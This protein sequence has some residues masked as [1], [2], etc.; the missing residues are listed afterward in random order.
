MA[1]PSI[2][3]VK[4]NGWNSDLIKKYDVAGPR[5]TSYPTVPNF[6]SAFRQAEYLQQIETSLKHSLAPLSL[7]VHVPFC[8]NICF[9][10]GCNK[11]VTRDTSVA[12]KYLNYLEKEIRLQSAAIGNRR[13]VMQ[14]HFGGGTPT[15][16]DNAELTE[17]MHALASH[18]KL[19]D[20]QQREY[21]I[22]LDPRTVTSDSLALLRGLGFNRVSF[23]IQDF[24][25]R[26]QKAINR[27]QSY[28]SV[29]ELVSAARLYRF[30]S[31]SFD[32]I[33][34]L[35]FQTP[36]SLSATIDQVTKLSP[37]RIA[38]Y[39]YAHLPERFSSQR[40]IDRLAL[41]SA[42]QKLSMWVQ[43]AERLMAAGYQFIGMDHFVKVDDDLAKA[44]K[45]GRLQRNFQ[46]YST[47]LAPDLVGL[48]VSSISSLQRCYA[49]NERDLD[50]YYDRL[51]RNELPVCRGVAL[52]RDDEIRRAIISDVICHLELD[53]NRIEVRFNIDFSDYF[54]RV[55]PALL[56]ME[57]DGLLVIEGAKILVTAQ[58]RAMLRNICM[59][60]DR[61]LSQ[62]S[63]SAFSRSL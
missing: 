8:K 26:V 19:T 25:L 39:N 44:Q 36:E 15:F 41:P 47:C 6:S 45:A 23:G 24:D 40:A 14:L 7:Y 31:V 21:S 58:G 49:Q 18:F 62:D 16:L 20:A 28:Q 57:I 50:G 27:V 1:I 17:L 38:F 48:G 42:E 3:L 30:R 60:F 52:S 46:G 35:P 11:I 4:S 56:E 5:Y 55:F 61:Y 32:L 12:R 13:P 2:K 54:S 34:G 63:P 51:A 22:E 10:C 53:I 33:Y 59:L 29:A 9:Y 43:I 37:D